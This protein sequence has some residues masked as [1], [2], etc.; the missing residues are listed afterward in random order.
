MTTYIKET[1]ANIEKLFGIELT[2]EQ[3]EQLTYI[4]ADAIQAGSFDGSIRDNAGEL[5]ATILLK[6]NQL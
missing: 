2:D 3:E 4:I 6:R 5:V 1:V